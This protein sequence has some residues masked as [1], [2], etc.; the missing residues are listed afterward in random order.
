MQDA[1]M[2]S[3]DDLLLCMAKLQL[4]MNKPYIYS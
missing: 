2:E 3:L 4:M 1:L